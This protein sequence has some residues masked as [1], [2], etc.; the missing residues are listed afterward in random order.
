MKTTLPNPKIDQNF[1]HSF[2]HVQCWAYR[3]AKMKGFHDKP[4]DPLAALML[5]TT[6][7]AEAAECLRRDPNVPSEHIPDYT[8]IEE[9]LADIIIRV[10]DLAEELG[11]EGN[12][13]DDRH[14]DIVGAIFAKI[15]FNS[16]RERLH[17]KTC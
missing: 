7:V 4:R 15:A 17:G 2:D 5:I 11:G 13:E 12:P 14:V 8:A 3:I 9:E 16:K 10:L 1:G 6:E